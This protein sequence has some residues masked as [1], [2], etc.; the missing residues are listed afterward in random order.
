MVVWLPGWFV[1]EL[2][3]YLYDG[4]SKD[5]TGVTTKPACFH[6]N[7]RTEKTCLRRKTKG[8]LIYFR[9]KQVS[10]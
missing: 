4:L 10:L 2:V 8:A 6:R 1:S 7:T 5:D 3:R 9:S